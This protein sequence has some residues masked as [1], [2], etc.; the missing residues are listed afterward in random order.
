MRKTLMILTGLLS[1][2]PEVLGQDSLKT[3]QLTEVVVTG[4]KFDVPVEKSGKTIFK[5]S[6]EDLEKNSGK[7][8]ADLLNEV[9]GIQTDGNFGTPG[10]NVSYYVRGG[11]NKNTLILIDGVPL[12]DPSAIHAEYD[13]RYIPVSQIESIEVLKGGLSTLYGTNAAAGVINITLKKSSTEK[14][15]G[16]VNAEAG[17]FETFTQNI[18]ISGKLDRFRYFV[19]GA[20]SSSG[21]F[22][23][24]QDNDPSTEFDKD[25]FS[26]QN[27]MTKFGFGIPGNVTI[28]VHAAWEKFKADFDA[29]EFFDAN[30]R[31]ENSQL[32]FG[33]IPQWEYARGNIQGKFFIN[34]NNRE[35]F[36]DYPSELDGTNLQGEWTHRHNFSDVVSLLSGLNYQSMTFNAKDDFSEVKGEDANIRMFDPYTSVFLDL[37]SGFN[38]H[39]GVR[40]N[41]HS[42]YGSKIVYNFNPSFL[43]N[44]NGSV[45]YKVFASASSSYITPTLYQLY[46]SYGNIDLVPEEAANYEAG[47]TI[48][49]RRVQFTSAFFIREETSPIEF[50]AFLDDEGNFVLQYENIVAER[51]VKGFEVTADFKPVMWLSIAGNFSYSTTDQPTTYYKIPKSKFGLTFDMNPVKSLNVSLK[52]NVTGERTSFD[53]FAN[54]KVHLERYQLI[55]LFASYGFLQGK[56]SVYGAVNNVLDEEFVAIYGYTTRGRNFNTGIRYRF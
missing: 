30:N 42:V 35:Y 39:A 15:S 27:V 3:T 36:G 33:L 7:S 4:T 54:E 19:S 50:R 29:F 49:D 23:A 17:S 10:T 52:Y 48:L 32:R 41:T 38:L 22:S 43:L 56:L 1:L 37:P 45:N 46:S 11:R 5:L 40:L 14:I 18:Q 28:D 51:T 55:D 44:K 6:K 16:E 21:G 26:R 34:R 8:V 12:N 24:A 31:Q 13:L 53:F 9:P 47:F 20:N 25:G 2:S